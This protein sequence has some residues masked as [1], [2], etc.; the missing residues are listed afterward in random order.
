M[1]LEELG[2]NAERASAFVSCADRG[3][4]PARVARQDR[5]GF[6]VWSHDARRVAVA[7]CSAWSVESTESVCGLPVDHRLDFVHPKK[8]CQGQSRVATF[9]EFAVA[10]LHRTC[11]GIVKLIHCRCFMIAIL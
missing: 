10:G 4:S 3:L 7:F 8:P 1:L 2:W 9:I 6:T 5:G 11:K